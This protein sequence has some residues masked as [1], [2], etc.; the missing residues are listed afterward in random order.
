MSRLGPGGTNIV[1]GLWRISFRGTL[2]VAIM[3]G[4]GMTFGTT[5]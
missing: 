4:V 1:K 2:A 5:T 3:A